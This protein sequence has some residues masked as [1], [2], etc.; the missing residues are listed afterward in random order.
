MATVRY[1][2]VPKSTAY[3]IP[4]QFWSIPL[5]DGRHACGRVLQLDDTGDNGR[6]FVA[7]LLDWSG[8][9][10]PT[11]QAIAGACVLEHGGVHVKT[12]SENGGEVIGMRPL[13]LDS[14]EVPLSLDEAPGTNCRLRRGYRLLGLAT[15]TQQEE[16]PV[17][18]TWGYGVIKL[19]AERHF[20]S[21]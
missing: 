7:G 11:S 4:G 20:G 17:F 18:R 3:L 6:L 12:I 9:G 15:P 2:F 1:P 5:D 14:I 16:I 19:L 8:D 10:P 13:E 21:D